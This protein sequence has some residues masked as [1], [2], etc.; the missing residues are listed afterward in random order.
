MPVTST[1][2]G[3]Q[4]VLLVL[5]LAQELVGWFR[6]CTEAV[7]ELLC[8]ELVK[9]CKGCSGTDQV[10]EMGLEQRIVSQAGAVVIHNHRTHV[11]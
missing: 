1:G 11:A 3:T 8:N 9:T 5:T 7:I 4:A 2:T 6:C 10:T